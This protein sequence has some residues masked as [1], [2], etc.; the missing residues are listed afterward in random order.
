MILE[1]S[2]SNYRSI[3]EEI[4]FSMV[5]EASKSKPDNVFEQAISK[6]ETVRLL[7]T[8]AIYGANASGKSNIIR[9]FFEFCKYIKRGVLNAGEEIP[10]YDPYLFDPEMKQK[11]S[12]FWLTFIGPGGFKHKYELAFN[13]QA[14]FHEN[15]YYYPLGSQR[16]IFTRPVSTKSDGLI[17]VASLGPDF[18]NKKIDTFKNQLLISKF[19]KDIPHEYISQ[20]YMYLKNIIVVNA[21]AN[22]KAAKLSKVANNLLISNPR[23]RERINGLLRHADT[24]L[25]RLDFIETD[26][27]NFHFPTEISDEERNK[28]IK[29]NKYKV[30]GM[31]PVYKDGKEIGNVGLPINE[32]SHGTNILFSMGGMFIDVLEKGGVIFID[33]LDVSLHPFLTKLMVEMFHN[34]DINLRNAQLIF[35]THDITLLNKTLL[36]K[37]QIWFTKKDNFGATELYSAQDFSG[38][39][40][41]TPFDKWYLAGKFDAIPDIKSIESL[42]KND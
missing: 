8:A 40:D 24:K 4:V 25:S 3:K 39:R 37:D 15:L 32:E 28:I 26:E 1:F 34:P 19:G 35:T 33:E 20:V 30:F 13:K 7:K 2:V 21:V 11:P 41:D 22:V 29:D 6:K 16:K 10:A 17:H 31:H 12:V 27:A 9:A 36:R 38:V 42:F 23:F 14:V 18:R 5:A